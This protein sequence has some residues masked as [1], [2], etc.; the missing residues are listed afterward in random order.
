MAN[1]KGE[2]ECINCA[3]YEARG[4]KPF[5]RLYSIKLPVGLGPYVVCAN[6]SGPDGKR[7]DAIWVQKNFP[8]R[9][10]LYQFD[11]YMVSQPKPVMHL[12]S[13]GSKDGAAA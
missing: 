7:L 13:P 6:W 10:T 5:C 3:A 8:E 9:D 4:D 12:G 1:H 2:P 11:I